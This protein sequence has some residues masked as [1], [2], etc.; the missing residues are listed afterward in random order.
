[1]PLTSQWTLSVCVCLSVG[2][3]SRPDP[4]APAA[5]EWLPA[6]GSVVGWA[7]SHPTLVPS[8][9]HPVAHTPGWLAGCWPATRPPLTFT[10]HL[11]QS[12]ALLGSPNN[13]RCCDGPLC[14]AP[15]CQGARQHPEAAAAAGRRAGGGDG[16]H[17]CDGRSGQAAADG[18]R[19][20]TGAGGGW[21]GGRMGG[22]T[23][24]LDGR[25]LDGFRSC[26]GRWAGVC[27]PVGCIRRYTI[28]ACVCLVL[29]A[30]V[31]ECTAFPPPK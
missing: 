4:S 10:P 22:T 25:V 24:V 7:T 6:A 1:M 21:A 12:L 5:D 16:G 23:G 15:L 29:W 14:D 11:L 20:V 28:N 30:W 18:L 19:V 9:H 13:P 17:T 31:G 2:R 27:Q 3:G 26:R 8:P